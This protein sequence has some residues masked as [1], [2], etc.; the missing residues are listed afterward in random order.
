MAKK[1]AGQVA[2]EA[3]RNAVNQITYDGKPIPEWEA[4]GERQRIGWRAAAEE[5]IRKT[6]SHNV[7]WVD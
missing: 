1:C 2:F 6:L 7:S 4:L 5:I 3:Y